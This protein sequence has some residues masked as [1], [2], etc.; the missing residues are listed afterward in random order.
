MVITAGEGQVF[1]VG[2]GAWLM[3]GQQ[4]ALTAS[5]WFSE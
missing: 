5:P 2:T 3:A 1:L 4:L